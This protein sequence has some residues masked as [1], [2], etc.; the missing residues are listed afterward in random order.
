MKTRILIALTSAGLVALIHATAPPAA[1]AIPAFARQ[2]G[3]S[4]T[5]CHAP[6]PRLTPLGE[7]FAANGF[8]FAVEEPPVDSVDTGD[9]LLQLMN[10]I[11]LAIRLDGYVQARSRGPGPA[12]DLQTPWSIKLLSGGRI[13]ERASYYLYFFMSERGEVAGLEDAYVQFSDVLGSGVDLLVGQFQ[14]SDP[15]FKRE[16]RLE[17]EDYQ[18]Y[19]VRVGTARADLTYDR[20]LMAAYSPWAGADMSVQV[21]NG[22][23]LAEAGDGRTYDSDDGKSVAGRLSQELGP[24]RVGGFGYYGVESAGG[25]DNRIRIFGPDLTI[26]VAPTVEVNGQYLRRMDG[27]PFFT[28]DA[29]ADTDVDMGFVELIWLP[30]GVAGRWS[31]TALYNHV[32]ASAPVFTLRQGETG[33][34]ENYRAGALGGNYL[35]ARNLRLTGELQYDLDREGFRFVTGFTSAF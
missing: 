30:G 24:V 10:G 12:V 18:A 19:R 8:R 26:T 1:E 3:V 7:Q 15:L 2:Y 27:R 29:V 6:A 31:F 21:V 9:P 25:V 33:L 17:Y 5:L 11:P 20:G 16:L 34:L 35:L 32:A 13:S 28:D 23:G 14:V 4:C 22:R